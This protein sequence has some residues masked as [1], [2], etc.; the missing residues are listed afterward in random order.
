[1]NLHLKR[2]ISELSLS[3][4]TFSTLVRMGI[5]TIGDVVQKSEAEF[6]RTPNFGRKSMNDLRESL[7][8]CDLEFGMSIENVDK[9]TLFNSLSKSIA[10]KCEDSLRASLAKMLEAQ[11]FSDK[12]DAIQ[13]HKKIVN[14]Y[15]VAI[16]NSTEG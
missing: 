11:T 2:P 16:H 6:L 10:N 3:G 9:T 5:K 8:E 13:E 1:M 7:K 4:R 12:Y 15:E 14:S